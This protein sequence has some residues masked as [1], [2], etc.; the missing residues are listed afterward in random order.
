MKKLRDRLCIFS[1]ED[2]SIIRKCDLK[3]QLYFSLIGGLVLTILVCCFISAYLFTDSLF[4]SP[5]QDFG[6]AIIWGFIVTNLYV[7]LLYTIS[8]TFLPTSNKGKIIKKNENK[9][10]SINA[11]FILRI[12]LLILLAIIIAQPLN[13]WLLSIP[14]NTYANTIKT[15]LSTNIFSWLVTVIVAIIFL[16]PVYWKYSIRSLGGFYEV[17][18]NIEKRIIEDDYIDF[19]MD[20]KIIL[21][22]NISDFNKKTWDNTMPFLNKLE[23]VSKTKY[24]N[25]FSEISAE[26]QNENIEK[27]EYWADPPFRTIKKNNTK[28]ALT[29]EEFLTDIYSN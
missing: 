3:I 11:S 22:N 26:L 27:Y 8:P 4:H 23:I 19:K 21:E 5:I 28:S 14:S 12:G 6:I 10:N 29:E 15:L 20:Y 9:I 16:L 1:G 25:F 13:V 17:K 2:F 24:N 18:A 7:L